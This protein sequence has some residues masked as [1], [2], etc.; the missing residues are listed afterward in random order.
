MANEKIVCLKEINSLLELQMAALK[1]AAKWGVLPINKENA[2]Q[3]RVAELEVEAKRADVE[4]QKYCRL[5]RSVLHHWLDGHEAGITLEQAISK[6]NMER[7]LAADKLADALAQRDALQRRVEELE[8]RVAL[9]QQAEARLISQ[10]EDLTAERDELQAALAG[11]RQRVAELEVEDERNADQ[12]ANLT[13]FLEEAQ[14]HL[15]RV[16]SDFELM[17]GLLFSQRGMLRQ[18]ARAGKTGV[19]AKEAGATPEQWKRLIDLGFL[20]IKDGRYY[21]SMVAK[22]T[23]KAIGERDLEG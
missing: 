11:Y 12:I 14:N 15:Q 17:G 3:Q 8:G 18:V 5:L 6:V 16:D 7:D 21:L 13:R 23:L 22:E 4:S 9:L 10:N 19:V 1:R 2:L 20:Q